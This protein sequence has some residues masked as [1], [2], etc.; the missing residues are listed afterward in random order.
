M[1]VFGAYARYYDLLYHDKDYGAEVNFIL[2]LIRRH[3]PTA[4]SILELGCGTGLHACLMAEE[5]FAVHGIDLS[6]GMLEEAGRRKAGLPV[7]LQYRLNFEAADV[8]TYRHPGVFDIVVSLFHVF[9][10]Q[11]SNADLSSAFNTAAAHLRPGGILVCDFWYGPAVLA[12]RPDT[13]VKRLQDLDYEIIRIAEP[14][15]HENTNVV[16]VNYDIRIIERATAKVEALSEKHQLRY[17]FLPELELF[18]AQSS[19]T[20][21]QSFSWLTQ[22]PPSRDSWSVG[23]VLVKR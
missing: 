14:V 23:A 22:D 21:L 2:S 7:A 8:R 12:Q 4:K 10:Y 5:G 18:A 9:S 6:V 17:I 20:C 13:R 16:D 11:T 15:L 1:S 19:M 3:A